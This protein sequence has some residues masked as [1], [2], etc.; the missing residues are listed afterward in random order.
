MNL[1]DRKCPQCAFEAPRSSELERHI[2]THTGE[3]PFVCDWPACTY[4]A[5]QPGN[6]SR[7][8]RVHTGERPYACDWPDCGYAAGQKNSLDAH[9][10]VHLKLDEALDA[11]TSDVGYVTTRAH[12][13]EESPIEDCMYFSARKEILAKHTRTHE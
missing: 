10:R 7:H 11:P 6:L 2:R 9:R 12:Q 8:R 4:A 5:S 1:S 13:E 3:R